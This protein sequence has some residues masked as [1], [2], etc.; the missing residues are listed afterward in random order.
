[1][2]R[3]RWVVML[4]M[5]TLLGMG[6]ANRALAQSADAPGPFAVDVRV[7]MPSFA[8][9]DAQAQALNLEKVQL[10]R[11]GLGLDVGANV[12]PLRKGGFALGIGAHY[13]TANGSAKATTAANS[14]NEEAIANA[15]KIKTKFTALYPE[16]SLNFGSRRGWSYLSGGIG[17]ARRGIEQVE[18]TPTLPNPD[19]EMSERVRTLHYGGGARWLWSD[20]IGFGFD[21][22]WHRMPAQEATTTTRAFPKQSYFAVGG[23]ITIK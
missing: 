10:P 16:V 5:G 6:P 19:F 23:G 14:E 15:P 21:M 13:L 18:G 4:S 7:V 22:R 8:P 17:W 11:R 20:H 3:M 12:Y 9:T 2:V 1:M